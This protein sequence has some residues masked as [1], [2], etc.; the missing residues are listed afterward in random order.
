MIA[1]TLTL[2]MPD[3]VLK[4]KI[5]KKNTVYVIIFSALIG[6][7]AQVLS[8]LNSYVFYYRDAIYRLEKARGF[9][10]SNNPGF[11]SQLGT[12]WLPVTHIMM[13]P[14]A[15]ID[16]LWYTGIAGSLI[17]YICF[18]FNILFI[19][20]IL[21]QYIENNFAKI[22]GLMVYALNP[23]LLYFQTT[24]LTEQP[25]LLFI[26][27]AFY[28]MS[29]YS[30]K[31]KLLFL[32]Y[33]GLFMMLAMG[34]RYDGW[35]MFLTLSILLFFTISGLR[36]KVKPLVIF[37]ILPV[38][39]LIF[40]FLYNWI[41][42]GDALEFSRGKY[43]TL[44]QLIYYEKAGRLLTKYSI[45]NSLEVTC[46]DVLAYVG[47][48]FI[49]FTFPGIISY[50]IK[51]KF[52]LKSLLPY[53]LLVPFPLMFLLLFSGQIIIELPNTDPPGYFNSRYAICILPAIAFFVSF[54][55][56]ELIINQTK[57]KKLLLF[58]FIVLISW[59]QYY[60]FSSYPLHIPAI[61]EPRYY[62]GDDTTRDY[63]SYL[64][65]NYDGG[66]V[67]YDYTIF[68]LSPETRIN[69]R[70]R[71]TY[72]TPDIG[73]EAIK[74]PKIYAKWILFYDKSS[75]DSVYIYLKDNKKFYDDYDNVFSNSGVNIFKLK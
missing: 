60:Y 21:Q 49:I 30:G 68:A 12:V 38:C 43:S 46:K 55:I 42:Y 24:A 70:D 63:N 16:L 1:A 41:Y 71:L 52:N 61:A 26:T 19:Y 2:N 17:G 62:F 29:K 34:T 51:T 15:Y 9:F 20:L 67:L 4:H 28:F 33:S 56:Q 66:K 13:A 45:L 27:A 10:D 65:R 74:D 69:I 73:R 36:N 75:N 22:I 11:L 35:A 25:Y 7:I 39:F 31:S 14:F 5:N 50:I 6:L 8:Y 54:F 37:F 32:L 18:V 58:V 64:K 72:Y 23:N 59:Q 48:I 44:Q 53:L 47:I 3:I 40:W 57:I